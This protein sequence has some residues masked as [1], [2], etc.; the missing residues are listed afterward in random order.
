MQLLGTEGSDF[1]L[2]L[3]SQQGAQVV[4]A[5]AELGERISEI[6]VVVG[7]ELFLDAVPVQLIV[8]P[9][10]PAD[11]AAAAGRDRESWQVAGAAQDHF[12]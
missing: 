12:N 2:P 4:T 5:R 10:S 8:H 1:A 3:L 7:G 9:Y 11:D 6:G